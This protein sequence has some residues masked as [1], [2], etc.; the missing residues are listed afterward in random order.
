MRKAQHSVPE[1][2]GSWTTR[3]AYLLAAVCLLVGL[4][5]GYLIRGS[6]APPATAASTTSAAPA[7]SPSP[8]AVNPMSAG[9]DVDTAAA[10]L[11]AALRA[12][13]KN[14]DVLVQLGNL[15]FDKQVFAPAIE[16]YRRALELDPTLVTVQPDVERLERALPD[17]AD[18]P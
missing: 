2:T 3:E 14:Y 17:K 4:A 7:A 8:A 9:G 11:K 10:P 16:Y 18:T 1:T 13:P 15:Y 12:D 6:S 5:L